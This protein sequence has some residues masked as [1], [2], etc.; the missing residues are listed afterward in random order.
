[1]NAP[2]APIFW[3]DRVTM[4]R[5]NPASGPLHIAAIRDEALEQ[6]SHRYSDEGECRAIADACQSY[7]DSLMLC[8]P[9]ELT[10]YLDE[11]DA[12]LIDEPRE[13][14]DGPSLGLV[15][16]GDVVMGVR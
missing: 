5:A 7:L 6:A 13:Y 14:D 11:L 16:P 8:A 2:F 15:W 9:S 1:M 12:L 10:D 3:T 4:A